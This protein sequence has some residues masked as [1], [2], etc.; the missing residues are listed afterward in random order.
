MI[1]GIDFTYGA[2]FVAL[3]LLVGAVAQIISQVVLLHAQIVGRP[4]V[5]VQW[6]LTATVT[7]LMVWTGVTAWFWHLNF[8]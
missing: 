5:D 8:G 4:T 6:D 7:N 3:S 1:F 2:F